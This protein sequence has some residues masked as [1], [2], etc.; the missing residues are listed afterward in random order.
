[1]CKMSVQKKK[2]E[3]NWYTARPKLIAY[4]QVS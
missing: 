1:M 4:M 3:E 2:K